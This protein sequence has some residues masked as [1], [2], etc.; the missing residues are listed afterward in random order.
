MA[1][2]ALPFTKIAIAAEQY[3]PPLYTQQSYRWFANTNSTN[4]GTPLAAQNTAA[5]LFNAGEL[6]RLRTL[7]RMDSN[8]LV[9]NGQSFKLQFAAQSGTCDTAFSG[10][11]YADVT[12]STVIAYYDNALP[13][14]EAALTANASDPTDGGRTIV[15]QSYQE[16]NNFTN[17]Q[18]SILSGQ[19][20]KWDFSLYDNDAPINTTYCFRVVR[21]DGTVLNTYTALPQITT[22]PD[23]GS[24]S[25]DIVDAGGI[26]VASPSM[27]MN[28]LILS[29]GYQTATGLSGVEAQKIRIN[30][31]TTNTK[32]SMSIAADA[33]MTAFW[34]GAIDYDFNDPTANAGDGGD[35]DTF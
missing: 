27:Q 2:T 29:L 19:D 31:T 3:I 11:T 25:V 28:S 5:T 17:S 9:T 24:L 16:L 35:A 1:R 34:D 33:G 18:A 12:T 23:G 22:S 13:A 6:F 7:L 26:S 32:W 8:G 15:N 14:D 30:N 10:E 20:G 4:V 21:S